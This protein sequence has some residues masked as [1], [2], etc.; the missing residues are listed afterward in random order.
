MGDAGDVWLLGTVMLVCGATTAASLAA[1]RGARVRADALEHA[2]TQRASGTTKCSASERHPGGR[3]DREG[4]AMAA[5]GDDLRLGAVEVMRR[6]DRSVV[7]YATGAVIIAAS[8]MFRDFMPYR[9]VGVG[10]I[11]GALIAIA[12]FLPP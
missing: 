7:A 8:V 6:D 12:I 4:V 9:G 11:G 3:P 1:A 2:L 5:I 10:T